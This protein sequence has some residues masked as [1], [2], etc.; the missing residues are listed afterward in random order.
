MCVVVVV[1]GAGGAVLCM[2]RAPALGGSD[3]GL[4]PPAPSP[5][6]VHPPPPT[7]THTTT[8]THKLAPPTHQFCRHRYRLL[9]LRLLANSIM[10]GSDGGDGK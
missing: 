7:H 6:P 9:L 10:L 1:G 5:P 3:R 4:G 2:P 8:T